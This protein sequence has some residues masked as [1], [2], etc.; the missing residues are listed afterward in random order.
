M[1]KVV[2]LLSFL[3][4]PLMADA[5]YELKL[6]EK[7]FPLIM[8]KPTLKVFVEDRYK[9]IFE[10]SEHILLVSNCRNA[11][12]I[13]AKNSSMLPNGCASK[14]IFATQFKAFSQKNVFGVFYWKKGRPQLV[15]N[16]KT[17]Q[18]KGLVLP[19]SLAKYAY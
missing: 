2:L 3:L 9:D 18:E 16:K 17:I 4:I 11:D 5:N 12:F 14:P 6:Y 19:Q 13:F 8:K 1:K 15:F 10:D 7:I